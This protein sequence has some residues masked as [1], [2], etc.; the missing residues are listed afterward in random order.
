MTVFLV[1]PIGMVIKYSFLDRAVVSSTPA[2]VGIKNYLTLFADRQFWSAVSHTIIF[3]VVS[4]V[5]H[6]ILGMV[7]A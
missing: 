4:V 5:A 2:F 7:F 6:L 3:V 1:L